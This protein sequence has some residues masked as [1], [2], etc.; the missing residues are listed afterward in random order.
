MQALAVTMKWLDASK[1]LKIQSRAKRLKNNSFLISLLISM[2]MKGSD[3]RCT[4]V[5]WLKVSPV[6]YAQKAMNPK[7]RIVTTTGTKTIA[8]TSSTNSA[9]A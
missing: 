6:Q 9:Q 7:V 2:L 8:L 4:R 1:K 3:L 5:P